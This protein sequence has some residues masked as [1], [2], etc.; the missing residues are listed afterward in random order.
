MNQWSLTYMNGILIRTLGVVSDINVR[1]YFCRME[2]LGSGP[3]VFRPLTTAA[4]S[5]GRSAVEEALRVLS[6]EKTLEPAVVKSPSLQNKL[7]G[8][9]D[10]FFRLDD[11]SLGNFPLLFDVFFHGPC[12]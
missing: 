7:I 5:F 3:L 10:F 11:L 1:Q 2:C 9:D 8:N 6:N 12:N 4:T